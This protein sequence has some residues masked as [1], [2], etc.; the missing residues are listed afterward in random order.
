M[1]TRTKKVE[2]KEPEEKEEVENMAEIEEEN[3]E[4]VSN[5]ET[6]FIYVG[7]TTNSVAQF[8]VFKNGYPIQMK[9]D[10]EKYNA[11]K[12]LFI[13]TS[14]LQAFQKNV[15]VKGTVENIRF[16]EAKKYFKKKAV[17]K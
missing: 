13:P 7:P 11:L 3:M 16:E 4:T 8:T 10:L 14:Q 12:N 5:K 17:N 2:E 15:Q 1:T 9:E 6:V